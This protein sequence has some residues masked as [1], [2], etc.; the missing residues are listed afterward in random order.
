ME[1]VA[2]KIMG[3]R[4]MILFYELNFGGYSFYAVQA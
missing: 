4:I 2:D 1:S 3:H